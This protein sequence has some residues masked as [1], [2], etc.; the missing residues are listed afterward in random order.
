MCQRWKEGK[1][2]MLKL[3]SQN[4]R[5]F[6]FRSL[7]KRD[8]PANNSRTNW[9]SKHHHYHH[10]QNHQNHQNHHHHS[11]H[12]C[13]IRPRCQKLLC[14]RFCAQL[15]FL[16]LRHALEPNA[17]IVGHPMLETQDCNRELTDINRAAQFPQPAIRQRFPT[18]L[19]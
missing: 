4:Y 5:P 16:L 12:H 8:G 19:S 13:T 18:Q 2:G 10:Y 3:T 11:N 15:C 14:M 1:K 7:T 9:G 6:N 17:I